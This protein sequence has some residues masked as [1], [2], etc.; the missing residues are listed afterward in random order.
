MRK[1]VLVILALLIFIAGSIAAQDGLALMKV[2]SGARAAGLGGAFV[3]IGAD[4]LSP[5]YNPAGAAGANQFIA[6]FGYNSYWSNINMG[7][8]YFVSP[9]V[10]NLYLHGG[11]RYAGVNNLEGRTIPTL[12]PNSVT[13]FDANDVSFKAGLSYRLAPKVSVG[14]AAGWYVEKIESYRGSAFN[15]DLGILAQPL[16]ALA[17]GASATNVGPDFKIDEGEVRSRDISLPTMYRIGGSYRYR[18]YLGALDIVVVDDDPHAHFG[19]E[20]DLHESFA[21]RA[22]YMSGYDTKNITAG[23]SF[24]RRNFTFDYA[25]VP[26]SSD[27][28]TAHLFNLTI[29]L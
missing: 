20:A 22:G 24:K 14:A 11:I 9:L 6:T 2:E 4:P 21:I 16:P 5:V 25:F 28:G 8:G 3:S 26:Y 13:D 7:H 1:P 12:D 29:A 19:A 27:L 15:V 23:A 10:G 17:I 18:K